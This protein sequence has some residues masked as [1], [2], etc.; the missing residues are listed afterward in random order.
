MTKGNKHGNK[1]LQHPNGHGN[2]LMTITRKCHDISAAVTTNAASRF[3]C[4]H[5]DIALDF[6]P[7]AIQGYNDI[8]KSWDQI[9]ITQISIQVLWGGDTHL[10]FPYYGLFSYDPDG[11]TTASGSVLGKN[12]AIPFTVSPYKS[13]PVFKVVPGCLVSNMV[14]TGQWFDLAGTIPQMHVG[15]LHLSTVVPSSVSQLACRI[16]WQIHYQL[17]GAR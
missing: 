6:N 17:R 13:S 7:S 4:V 11:Y 10:A 9:R 15:G 12:N 5:G 16:G 1:A 2:S 8:A 3:G 14:K